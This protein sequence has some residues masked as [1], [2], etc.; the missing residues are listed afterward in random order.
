MDA[1][2]LAAG[3]G[4]RLRPLT[5]QTPKPL[6][7]VDQHSL[8]EHHL[9]RL[10]K[11]GFTRCIINVSWLG[12]KIIT[13]L[14]DGTKYGLEIIYSEENHGALETA[15]GI[16]QAL[17]LISSDVFI[18]ISGDIWT[19]FP[20]ESLT[21]PP[22]SDMHLVMTS[23]PDHHPNGDFVL[24]NNLL[25]PTRPD[26]KAL[27]YTGIG[28]FHRRIFETLVPGLR[29]LRPIIDQSISAERASGIIYNGVWM[30]IGTKQRLEQIR[31]L[32]TIENR[33]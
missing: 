2:I 30:D 16:R 10:K 22:N 17:D 31:N 7:R 9:F 1:F 18:V 14:G 6:L 15:G 4:E 13:T 25:R 33:E 19:D 5:D 21:L 11:S 28:C 12:Q 29:P 23:N 8:I 20:F 27:T 32:Q 3:R 26:S 24:K